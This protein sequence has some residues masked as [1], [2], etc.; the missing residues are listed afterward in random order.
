MSDIT[1]PAIKVTNPRSIERWLSQLIERP[2]SIRF[3]SNRSTMM[4]WKERGTG[5]VLRIHRMFVDAPEAVWVSLAHYLTYEDKASGAIVDHYIETHLSGY[6]SSPRNVRP[7]G[8]CHDLLQLFDRLNHEF[9][10]NRCDVQITWGRPTSSRARQSI[11]LGSYIPRE[12]L[13]RIHPCLDQPFVPHYYVAWVIYHEMLH[14]V[15]GE[16]T[17]NGRRCVHPPEFRVLEESYPDFVRC[18]DWENKNL[19][20]L[21]RFRPSQ[22]RY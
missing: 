16:E 1:L 13:I 7:I 12:R 5:L 15:F 3:T 17:V 6:E 22:S 4:S 19:N 2:V 11:Q 18:K 9:F 20:R 8:K 14:E 21:L 10:H